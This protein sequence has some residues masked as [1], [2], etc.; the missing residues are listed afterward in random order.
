MQN[1]GFSSGDLGTDVRVRIVGMY[2][3]P[4][5]GNKLELVVKETT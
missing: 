1:I 2:F 4:D 5:S 3:N